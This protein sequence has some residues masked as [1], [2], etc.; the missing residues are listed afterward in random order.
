MQEVLEMLQYHMELIRISL[1][2]EMKILLAVYGSLQIQR[3]SNRSN[4][5]GSGFQAVVCNDKFVVGVGRGSS[6]EIWYKDFKYGGSRQNTSA[7]G[8]GQAS[9]NSDDT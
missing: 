5:N 2:L 1:H 8:M 4:M 3:G 6:G 7:S 9:I